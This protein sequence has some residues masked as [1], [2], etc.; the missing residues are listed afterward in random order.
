[1]F[2]SHRANV[3]IANNDG[4]TAAM[5]AQEKGHPQIAAVLEEQVKS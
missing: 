5:V 1:L 4:K 2:L 3:E